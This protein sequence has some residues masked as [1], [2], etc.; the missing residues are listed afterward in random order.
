MLTIYT[1]PGFEAEKEY[2]CTVL[3]GELLGVSWR[4]QFS[5]EVDGYRVVLPNGRTVTFSDNFWGRIP[6]GE[7]YCSSKWLPTR[8]SSLSELPFKEPNSVVVLYGQPTFTKTA[9]GWC[10]GL[11]IFASTF[12]M[13]SRWEEKVSPVRDAYGRFPAHASLAHRWGFLHRPVVNEYASFL[14]Q[15]LNLLGYPLPKRSFSAR[16]HLSC[17]VDHPRLWWSIGDR[18]RTLGGSLWKR[19]NPQEALWWL[20]HGFFH[21]QDPFDVFDAWME[22]AE[23]R[24]L[25]WHFNFFGKGP[26]GFETY[27]SLNHPFLR[28]LLTRIAERGHVIGFHPSRQAHEDVA[29]FD[30]ELTS[31]RQASPLPVTTGR[32]HYLCFSAPETWQR[33]ADAG[34]EWDSTLGYPEAEGFRCGICCDFPVFNFLTRQMLPLREKP[35]VAMDVTLALYQGYTPEEAIARIEALWKTIRLYGGELVLLWHNSSWN[36]YFWKDWRI[37]FNSC[38]RG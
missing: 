38:L 12:F 26:K 11:D 24:N 17:D 22:Q 25:V 14:A 31:L 33:W 20:R 30:Q 3:L 16:L 34:M 9:E 19:K 6:T 8:I 37:V 13:L 21:S 15:C 32:Q 4:L 29:S 18:F 28:R 5:S 7:H 23:R 35:L 1:R 2:S 27:Y 36:D 10:C